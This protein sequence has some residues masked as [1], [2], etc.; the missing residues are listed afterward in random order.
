MVVPAPALTCTIASPC[1]C[2]I[3]NKF[4][5]SVDCCGGG[6]GMAGEP[7]ADG[8]AIRGGGGGGM[9]PDNACVPMDAVCPNGMLMAALVVTGSVD[10]AWDGAY[11]TCGTCGTCGIGS[12]PWA[13]PP[14][15]C[16][17]ACACA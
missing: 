17:N 11:G 2:S 13:C 10:E 6:F 14:R 7:L 1:A 16:A 9:R 3:L 12:R 8:G 15:A 5:D 4:S